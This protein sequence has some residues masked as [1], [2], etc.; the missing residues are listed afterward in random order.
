MLAVN[1]HARIGVVTW[2]G[3][4]SERSWFMMATFPELEC[5]VCG[6]SVQLSNKR[7]KL[8]PPA[9]ANEQA[10]S[11][12][13]QFI[14][15]AH[16]HELVAADPES[17]YT[18]KPCFAKLEKANRHFKC[19]VEITSDLTRHRSLQGACSSVTDVI[20]ESLAA[21]ASTVEQGQH[22]GLEGSPVVRKRPQAVRE[23]DELCETT[24][25]RSCTNMLSEEYSQSGNDSMVQASQQTSQSLME[26][27]PG[28]SG[29]C[30]TPSSVLKV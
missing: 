20:T 12:F 7:R 24:P 27:Q 4:G 29:T 21:V 18:C 26:T 2:S 10:R 3:I 22:G 25:K 19:L 14:A 9:V 23:D 11:F 1:A 8:Y 13:V 28:Q 16:D 5:T 30:T 15:N 17:L 6:I